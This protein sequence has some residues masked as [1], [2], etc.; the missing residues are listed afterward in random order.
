MKK[1]TLFFAVGLLLF[2]NSLS[3]STLKQ[4]CAMTS[5][6]LGHE[7]KYALYLPDGYTE[8]DRDY[9]VLYLLHGLGN[10]YRAWIQLGEVQAIADREIRS[11]RSAPMIIVMPEAGQT[12]YVNSYDGKTRYEDMFVREL[13]PHIEQTCRARTEKTFRAVAGLSMGGY[14]SLLY[15]I[16][17][18]DLFAACCPM[19]AAVFTDGELENGGGPFADLFAGF[20]G[21]GVTTD[22]WRRN[23]VLELV[24]SMPDDQRGAVRFRIDCGDDDFLYRGNSTL[25]ILMR[26]RNIPHEYR[27]RD[28][29]H[30]WTYWRESLPAALAFVSRSF[31]LS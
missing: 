18:P 12:W 13:I 8:G 5:R 9:P 6:I 1:L 22:H 23:S 16:R 4:E 21:P 11:G 10:D 3:A 20:F 28:G 27:V 19:S 7:V 2:L 25:H 24:R 26:E 30:T 14:G 17:Y 29:G 31:R 15:A